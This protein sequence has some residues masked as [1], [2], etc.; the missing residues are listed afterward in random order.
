M[1][2]DNHKCSY[3]H[4]SS[5]NRRILRWPLLRDTRRKRLDQRPWIHAEERGHGVADGLVRVDDAVHGGDEDVVCP[6]GEEVGD[7][8]DKCAGDRWRFDPFALL[9]ED[10][11]GVVV[12]LGEDCEGCG[13]LAS[14][15]RT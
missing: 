2:S 13:R 4:L 14:L 8:A 6:S 9:V 5:N 12:V 1:Q 15:I 7:V 3:T 10:L 11:E